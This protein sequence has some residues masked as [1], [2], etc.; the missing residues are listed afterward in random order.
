MTE[1]VLMWLCAVRAHNLVSRNEKRESRMKL[2]DLETGHESHDCV[3]TG[4]GRGN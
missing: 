1:N 3:H 2:G 4:R